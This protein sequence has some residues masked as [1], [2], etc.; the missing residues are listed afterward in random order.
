VRS[1]TTQSVHRAFHNPIL[2]WAG[3]IIWYQSWALVK[4]GRMMRTSSTI[5]RWQR[6]NMGHSPV[7]VRQRPCEPHYSTLLSLGEGSHLKRESTLLS[8]GGGSHLKRESHPSSIRLVFWWGDW[9]FPRR[10]PPELRFSDCIGASGLP[11]LVG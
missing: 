10:G 2:A 5:T 8:L 11:V 1:K 3:L 4:K 6:R 7:V 9:A